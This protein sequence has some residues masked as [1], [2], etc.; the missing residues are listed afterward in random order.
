MGKNLFSSG[1]QVYGF[2]TL[3]DLVGREKGV[4]PC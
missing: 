4:M 2:W 3:K 1:E